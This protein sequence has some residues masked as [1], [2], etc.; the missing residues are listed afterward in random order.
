MSRWP[1]L[2]AGAAAATSALIALS[3]YT[4]GQTVDP[5]VAL[6]RTGTAAGEQLRV[7]GAGWVPGSTLVVELCGQGAIHGSPD[8]AVASQVIVGAD[9]AGTF[10][11][12]LT[13]SL[14]PSP[15]PCVVK[16]A[17][18]ASHI[19]ATAAVAV[20]GIPTVPITGAESGPVQRGR[21]SPC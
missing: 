12:S 19:A 14:P 11:T 3:S 13:V 20:Q 4:G 2:V 8:C 15:C 9:A 6:D 17:D 5:T 10:V 16:A 21:H 18:E 7:T 1:R